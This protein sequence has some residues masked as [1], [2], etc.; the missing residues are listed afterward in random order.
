MKI[1]KNNLLL[2]LLIFSVILL[3]PIVTASEET[4][5]VN[6][7]I[8]T[9]HPDTCNYELKIVN[10]NNIFKSGNLTASNEGRTHQCIVDLPQNEY[11]VTFSCQKDA[12]R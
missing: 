7:R 10:S 2:A 3:I 6:L 1:K 8:T 9:L 5:P 11:V 12:T 4:K